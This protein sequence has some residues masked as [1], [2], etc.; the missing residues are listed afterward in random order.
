MGAREG[1]A[2]GLGDLNVLEADGT[3]AHY[4]LYGFGRLVGGLGLGGA[5]EFIF[6]W[7]AVRPSCRWHSMGSHR[8]Y[9]PRHPS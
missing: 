7:G 2:A 6:Y 3:A 1:G 5:I 4:V 8:G 9:L